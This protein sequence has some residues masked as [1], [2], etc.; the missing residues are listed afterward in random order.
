MK[1]LLIT[2]V[3]N[4]TSIAGRKSKELQIWKLN[5]CSQTTNGPKTKS[6]GKVSNTW[7]KKKKKGNAT[8]KITKKLT[9]IRIEINK[10]RLK[11]KRQGHYKKTT[12]RIFVMSTDAKT[13]QQNTSQQTSGPFSMT[14][15]ACAEPGCKDG[16]WGDVLRHGEQNEGQKHMRIQSM[17][18]K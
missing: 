2:V 18:K 12:G 17:K 7:D 16:R 4:W 10:Y 6:K 5:A 15:C 8:H 1:Y 13:P 11:E 3:W 14:S 9:K